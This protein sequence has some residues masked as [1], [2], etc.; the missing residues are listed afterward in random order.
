MVAKGTEQ[1]QSKISPQGRELTKDKAKTEVQTKQPVIH[2]TTRSS[3]GWKARLVWQTGG[4]QRG[5]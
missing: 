2:E 3:N 1:K 5:V 4:E